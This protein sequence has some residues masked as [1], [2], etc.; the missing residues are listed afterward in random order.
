M[1]EAAKLLEEL[2]AARP[3]SPAAQVAVG[4]ALVQAKEPRKAIDTLERAVE[5][6]PD[7]GQANAALV[8]AQLNQKLYADAL[9]AAERFRQKNPNDVSALKLVATT[10]AARGD[11]VRAIE[12]MRQA[13]AVAPGDHAPASYLQIGCRQKISRRKRERRWTRR[14]G[15]TPTTP[16]C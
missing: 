9:A 11:R 8:S 15:R 3:E 13:L 5:L 7:A 6:A 12:T 14:L 4:R 1:Q 16:P 10:H 2:A